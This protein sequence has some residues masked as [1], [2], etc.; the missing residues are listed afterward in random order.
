VRERE[1]KAKT[2]VVEKQKKKKAYGTKIKPQEQAHRQHQILP[3]KKINEPTESPNLSTRTKG[4]NT[5]KKKKK[6][7]EMK[8][9]PAIMWSERT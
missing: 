6:W 2:G 9:P 1:A 8:K 7:W 3:Q 4:A 5:K